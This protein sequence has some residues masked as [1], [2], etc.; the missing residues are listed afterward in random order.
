MKFYTGDYGTRQK[1]ANADNAS[2]YVEQHF[3]SNEKSANY[4]C[5]IVGSNASAK[6][7][8]IAA[9][10]AV[11]CAAQFGTTLPETNGVIVGGFRDKS[12]KRR[13][14]SNVKQT[15]MPA[16]LLEPLF[17]NN[18]RHAAIIRSG[19]GR[20]KL[21]EILAETIQDH[22]PNGGLIAFSVGHKYKK[23]RPQ[24]KGAPVLGGGWEADFAEDVLGRAR[25]LL[26][27]EGD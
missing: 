4:T 22:F 21:A 27:K 2:V 14:D 5:V 19:E 10:Y 20:Q 13:G 25:E 18:E 8:A 24:D 6:S 15:K 7:K 12:G 9:S 26:L 17:C 1:A 23:T 11:R 16:V 3:N